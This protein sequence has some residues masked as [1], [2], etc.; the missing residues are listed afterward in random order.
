VHVPRD[1]RAIK[2][3]R[4]ANGWKKKSDQD[5]AVRADGDLGGDVNVHLIRRLCAEKESVGRGIVKRVKSDLFYGELY[6][7]AMKSWVS[8]IQQRR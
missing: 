5:D 3:I 2:M 8:A 1:Y 7:R 4:E 6:R